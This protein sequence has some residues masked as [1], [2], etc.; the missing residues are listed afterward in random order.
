MERIIP[1]QVI[2][3]AQGLIDLYGEDFEY[4]GVYNGKK[5]YLF[6]FPDDKETGFPFVY[7]FDATSDS[8]EEITG[9]KALDIIG[10]FG[11]E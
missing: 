7:L 8:V 10:K 2:N 9:F 6:C 11:N 1:E 4:M 3:K 5:A